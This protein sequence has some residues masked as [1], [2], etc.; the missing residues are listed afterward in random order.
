MTESP[1]VTALVPS[2]NHGR[3]LRQR[4]ESILQQTYTNLELIVIDDCSEDDSDE[5]IRSL[6]AQYSFKYLRNAR[7]TGT[8][9]SAWEYVLSRDGVGKYVWICESD[10]YADPR[11]LEVTVAALQKNPVAVLAYCD[12]WVV[13]EGGHQVGH[14]D[15]FFHDIWH[16]VRWDKAFIRNGLEELS[17]F[18]VRGQTVPNMSSALILTDAFR[19][20]Y[21]PFLKKLKLT[22]DWLFIG[23]LMNHG[24]VVYCKETLSYFRRHEVT[25]RVR[26]KSAR[27]QAEF[28]LTKY[29]LFRASGRPMR[30]F[31][32]VMSTD[33]I[34]F[35]HEPAGLFDVLRVLFGI[36]IIKTL[37][38]GI[39]LVASLVLNAHLVKKFIQRYLFVN[40]NH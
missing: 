21:H 6:Q 39:L 36:S 40:R 19:K 23:W 13:D 30:E 31:A 14:T 26:V 18:Q 11:F 27:S 16:E 3:Y 17:E 8:P 38:A 20:A 7:N 2:Y 28:V 29:W 24:S 32:A 10:D 1:K 33:G 22:G 12:S 35:L 25:A 34:R 15:T 37:N 4:I 9:F 5:V